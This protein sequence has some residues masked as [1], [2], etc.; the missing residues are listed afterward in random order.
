MLPEI[1]VIP[2]SYSQWDVKS[3]WYLVVADTLRLGTGIGI[4]KK[5]YLH[6]LK[7]TFNSKNVNL[8]TLADGQIMIPNLYY[9]KNI[10]G[11]SLLLIQQPT[12]SVITISRRCI[13]KLPYILRGIS[14]RSR[15]TWLVGLS[16]LEEGSGTVI[17]YLAC[18]SKANM[19]K[20]QLTLN[21]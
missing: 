4:G 9:R 11:I 1:K 2:M 8:S 5:I 15:K 7:R 13:S 18:D 17:R 14:R 16:T 10:F 12:H 20:Q 21:V 19:T 6:V 3:V